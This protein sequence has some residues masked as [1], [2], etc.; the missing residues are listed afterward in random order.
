[1]ALRPQ[2]FRREGSAILRRQYEPGDPVGQTLIGRVKA[3]GLQEGVSVENHGRPSEPV[4][5]RVCHATALLGGKNAL[6]L[7]DDC[8]RMRSDDAVRFVDEIGERGPDAQAGAASETRFRM[9]E[10][11]GKNQ[12]ICR[13]RKYIVATRLLKTG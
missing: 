9:R 5:D 10:N 8:T 2:R 3:A 7:R 1:M 11:P 12:I 6:S 13:Q 4:P